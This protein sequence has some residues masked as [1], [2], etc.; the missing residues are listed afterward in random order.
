VQLAEFQMGEI[1]YS[2]ALPVVS[3]KYGIGTKA[4][5]RMN[6]VSKTGA[7]LR[8]VRSV[9]FFQKGD[10]LRLTVDFPELQKKKVINAEIVWL[11]KDQIGVN[12]VMPDEVIKKL[13]R[14]VG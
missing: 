2:V 14:T 3:E 9:E 8:V 4:N 7:M 13:F 10:L 12:F 6:N 5:L 1:R 11:E